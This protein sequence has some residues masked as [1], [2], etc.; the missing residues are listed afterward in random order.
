MLLD[1]G[2]I[3]LTGSA[4]VEVVLTDRVENFSNPLRISA[5]VS[6]VNESLAAL[7]F[8]NLDIST[9]RRLKDLLNK[10]P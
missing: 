8:R 2:Q 9:F 10:H 7:A 4:R 3:R 1:T 6:R 5:S